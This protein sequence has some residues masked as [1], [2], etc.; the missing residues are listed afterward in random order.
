MIAAFYFNAR[1]STLKS[2]Q[3]DTMFYSNFVFILVESV[4]T[5]PCLCGAPK[6]LQWWCTVPQ[7]IL[8]VM[9]RRV[10]E[11]QPRKLGV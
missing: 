2:P 3:V 11:L 4:D 8:L 6:L 1:V 10:G 9:A 5:V 7:R